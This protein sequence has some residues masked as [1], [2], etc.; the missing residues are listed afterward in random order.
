MLVSG[1]IVIDIEKQQNVLSEIL[2]FRQVPK[3]K[4]NAQNKIQ[5]TSKILLKVP[6]YAWII[7]RRS[8]INCQSAIYKYR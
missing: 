4:S 8:Y 2:T 3:W 1:I 7:I 6:S 5:N